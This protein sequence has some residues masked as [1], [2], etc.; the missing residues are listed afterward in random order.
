MDRRL[1][2]NPDDAEALSHRGWLSLT[3]GRQSEAIADLDHLYRRQP[4]HPD[5]DWM[6]GQAYQDGDNPAGALDFFGRVLKRAPEDQDTR[7]Q[8]GLIA[9]ALGRTQQAADD[10]ARVLAAHPTRD[11]VRYQH[12][13]ALNRLGRYRDALAEVDVLFTRHPNDFALFQL[14]GTAYDALGERGPARLA[15]EKAHSFL[16]KDPP[17][18][19]KHARIMAAGPLTRRDP[20][21]A[22]VLARLAV[23]LAPDQSQYLNTL[24]LA[25][26]GVGRYSEAINVLEQSPRAGRSEPDAFD[27]FFLAMAHHSLGHRGRARTCFDRANH[28]RRRNRSVSPQHVKELTAVR[29]EAEAVLAGPGGDL[30]ADVFAPR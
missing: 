11:T 3:E 30:P 18:L 22:V 2:V 8:R 27:L 15:W 28:L 9:F 12:A 13:R 10:F 4:D 25:L 20:D 5:V 26:Y 7:F 23:T 17:E 6:L 1:A 19:N 21:R 16:P 14:R 24:G 29:A